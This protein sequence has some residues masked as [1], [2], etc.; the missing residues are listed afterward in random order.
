MRVDGHGSSDRA[1]AQRPEGAGTAGGLTSLWQRAAVLGSL[2][3]ASEIV[4]GSFLHNLG[5]PFSGHILTAIAV[6]LLVGGHRI[7]PQT[8]LIVRAGLIAAVMKSASPSAVLLG[9]MVA[10][11]MEGL[12]MEAGVRLARGRLGGYLVGG[13]LAMSWTLFHKLG[14]FL[15][16]YG[17]DAIRVYVDLVAWAER[18]VGPVPLGPWGP[19]AVLAALNL[20]VGAAA[21]GVGLRLAGRAGTVGPAP[22]LGAELSTWRR[23]M[24]P[25]SAGTF[26]PSLAALA[27]WIVALGLGLF[28]FTRVGLLSKAALAG[29]AVLAAA[30]RSR[31]ALRRLGRPGFW[32]S[33]LLVTLVAGAVFGGLSTRP[34]TDWLGG[35]AAGLGMS[36]HAVF[37]TTCFAA[38]SGELTHPW[39]RSRFDRIG[40]GQL[41]RAVQAAFATLPMVIAALPPGRELLRR[42]ATALAGL[43]PRLDAWL[44][45]LDSGGRVVGVV[46]GERGEGKTTFAGE[47]VSSLRARGLRVAGLLAPGEI[48]NGVRWSIDLVDLGTGQ[49]WPLATRDHASPWPALGSFRVDPEALER[50]SAALAAAAASGADLVVVD[51]VGPWE[52]AGQG[53]ASALASLRREAVPLVLVV[54]RK[55]VGEVLERVALDGAT[56]WNVESASVDE[57]AATI[58]ERL[59]RPGAQAASAA[60]AVAASPPTRSA[61]PRGRRRTPRG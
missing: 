46:T 59:G 34:G 52:L 57:V 43:L 26:A 23:R 31:R 13:A 14:G 6:A 50:G 25:G 60:P 15:L 42:P 56:V 20:A 36:L 29:L 53:W 4:L 16:T 5:V 28:A 40:G 35:L 19:L 2:W 44:A 27:G 11:A 61:P 10:I 3:A 24:D 12:A 41:P 32:F 54:R 1:S 37:V 22:W 48:R 45:G 30:L 33:L 7:W 51:E 18:Q 8:G 49:R 38:L 39:V 55:F 17:G 9:P 47:L 58:A 21:A